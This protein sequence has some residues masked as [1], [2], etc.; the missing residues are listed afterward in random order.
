[1]LAASAMNGAVFETTGNVFFRLRYEGT[2]DAVLATPLTPGDVALAEI[3]W[4]LAR[5]GS[6]AA[7]F[8]V[9]M[10]MLGLT[11]S[12]WALLLLPAALLVGL[13]FAAAGL[14]AVSVMRSW[15]DLELVQ[16]TTLPLFLFSATFVPLAD[17]PGWAEWIVDA[18]PLYQGVALCRD[19]SLGTVGPGALVHAAYLVAMAL[20]F[21]AIASRRIN[22][23]LLR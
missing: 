10:A 11:S 7:V 19:L 21:V 4:A 17:Y 8:T 14:A 6:Y 5:G 20:V 18:T 9:V 13:A 12:P 23:L 2:Y 16:L 22:R 15:A 3:L 1:M